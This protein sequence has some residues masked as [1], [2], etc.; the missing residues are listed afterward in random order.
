MHTFDALDL[1]C[2]AF[3]CGAPLE[4]ILV[5][6]VGHN[7]VKIA[8]YYDNDA[9]GHVTAWTNGEAWIEAGEQGCGGHVCVVERGQPDTD[10]V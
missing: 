2:P 8:G 7:L 1:D 5:C 9:S 10:R 3:A 4:Q 6:D